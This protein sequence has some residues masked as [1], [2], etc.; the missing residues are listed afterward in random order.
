MYVSNCH[1]KQTSDSLSVQGLR[2]QSCSHWALKW[3]TS[4]RVDSR[5]TIPV[6]H[7]KMILSVTACHSNAFREN[8]SILL[9]RYSSH[10]FC[11]LKFCCTFFL[12]I[13]VFKSWSLFEGLIEWSFAW[14]ILCRDQSRRTCHGC[15][16]CIFTDSVNKIGCFSRISAIVAF[17]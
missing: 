17:Y 3:G 14:C 13:R 15:H 4:R 12:A 1:Q 7:C 16:F 10:T 5:C 11:C 9:Y 2:I 6:T 8:T